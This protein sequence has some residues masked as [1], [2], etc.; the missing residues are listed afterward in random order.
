[1]S[2]KYNVF[3]EINCKVSIGSQKAFIVIGGGGGSKS[4]QV[5]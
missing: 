3:S 4:K 1:L 2:E 5:I